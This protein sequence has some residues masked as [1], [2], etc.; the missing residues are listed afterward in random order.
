M[1]RALAMAFVVA[2]CGEAPATV[3]APLPN[4]DVACAPNAVVHAALVEHPGWTILGI[5]ELSVD[6]RDLWTQ[7]RSPDCPG[8]ALLRMAEGGDFYAVTL[9]S[10]AGGGWRQKVLLVPSTSMDGSGVRVLV[11]PRDV[12]RPA[13]VW[14]LPPGSYED[15]ETGALVLL[16]YDGVAFEQIE[17]TSTIFYLQDGEVRSFLASE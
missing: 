10:N 8:L 15:R 2:A 16:P 12:I 1:L 4:D 5:D 9:I 17:A 13:V 7:H 11:E 3:E 6:D 14:R